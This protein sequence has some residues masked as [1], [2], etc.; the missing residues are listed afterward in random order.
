MFLLWERWQIANMAQAPVQETTTAVQQAPTDIPAATLAQAGNDVP[1]TVAAAQTNAG[2]GTDTSVIRVKTDVLALQITATGGTIIEAD[3]LKYPAVKN[4]SEP[5]ALMHLQNPGRFLFQSGIS[6][7]EG[8]A[9]THHEV[10]TA[11]KQEYLLADGQNSI[12]VPLTWEKDGI[13]VQ[14][15]FTFKRGSYEFTLQQQLF[16]HSDKN[17]RGNAYEQWVFGQPKA[18]KGLGQVSTYTG[19][20]ISTNSDRYEKV[21]LGEDL[22]TTTTDGWVAMIQHYFLGA[23]V[24]AQGKEQEFFSRT[25]QQTG[26]HFVGVISAVRDVPSGQSTDFHSTLYVGPKIQKNLE[27]VAPNLDKTVDYGILFMIGQPMYLVLS[28]INHIVGNWGWSIVIMTILIKLLFFVPSAWAYKSMAKMRR[29][30]PEM[31]RIKERYG[32][33]RQAASVAIM[34]LYKKEKVNPASGC[35]PMLLQIP[36]FI[37]FYW[38]LVESVALRHAPWIGWIHDLSARDPYF[39]LPV[40]NAILMFV[41]Q[42]LNPPPPDP[43]QAKIMM[44]LPLVFGFLFM[45]FPA[46]LVLYWTVSNAFGI[47]QQYVMN[48]RYGEKS[49]RHHKSV[50][51]K[52]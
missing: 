47:V 4:G 16:N 41:Q 26:D 25:N 20:V 8:S 35:L 12:T 48:K 40:I 10:F 52:A 13:T 17:W 34:Q 27:A 21:K 23:I 45:W 36:F 37:A 42:R 15:N 31:Q 43:M 29:L 32:D 50:K 19:G 7:V 44:M 3:L 28:A 39:I 22:N 14:K 18:K 5:L 46:G 1:T 9:P 38:V 33:D 49:P 51:A 30:G 11:P 24:P 2:T 6:A